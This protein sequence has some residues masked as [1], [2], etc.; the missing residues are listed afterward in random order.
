MERLCGDVEQIEV[1]NA[2]IYRM[3]RFC[4]AGSQR[5]WKIMLRSGIALWCI[6]LVNG[7]WWIGMVAGVR[8]GSW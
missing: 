6:R 8:V 2:R 7:G 5:F 4:T 1:E 3:E